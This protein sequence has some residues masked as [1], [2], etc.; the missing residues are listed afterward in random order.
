MVTQ[1][2]GRFYYTLAKKVKP[3]FLALTRDPN[4]RFSKS[5][6]AALMMN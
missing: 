6:I 1:V 3:A 5:R 2:T 4:P